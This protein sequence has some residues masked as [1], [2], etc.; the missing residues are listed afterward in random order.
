MAITAV[1]NAD[2]TFTLSGRSYQVTKGKNAAL[3]PFGKQVHDYGQV[4]RL[5]PEA[6]QMQSLSQHIGNSRFVRNHYLNDR[7]EYYQTYHKILTV[8]A[9]KKEWLPKLKEEFTF[10]KGTDKFALETALEKVDDAYKRFFNGQA[11]FPNF[12]SKNKPQGNKYTT[13]QTNDNIRLLIGED[14]LPYIQLPVIGKVRFVMPKG[15]TFTSLCPPGTR[16]LKATVSKSG[17]GYYEVSLGMET[18]IDEIDP[19]KSINAC[20]IFG[21][22]LGLHDFCI[23]SDGESVQKIENPRWIRLHEKRL[24]RLQKAMSRKQYDPKTHTGSKNREKARQKV[25]REQKK[26]ANQRK[27]YQHKRSREIADRCSAVICEDLNVKG[28]MKNRHLAKA[29]ASVG[30]Y[31]F[32]MKVKYK[33]EQAGRYFIQV[34]R[35]FAS[36]QTCHACGYQNPDVK[37]LK[38]REWDCP[39]CGIHNDRDGNAAMS[40][41]LEGIR[42]LKEKGIVVIS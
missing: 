30:W 37:D 13:K 25:A 1:Q 22:D 5:L 15:A 17:A 21:M 19:L 42:L 39:E 32:L 8:S 24:R 6:N 12:M 11:D 29:V 18:V 38:V 31:G 33:M 4:L 20:D 16:I 23:L 9:Y 34:S 41:R 10:L 3:K 14:G 26:I 36:S 27:D 40:V 35:W 2:G 7:I 28:M